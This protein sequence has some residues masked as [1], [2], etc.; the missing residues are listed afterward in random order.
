MVDVLLGEVNPN[1]AS[2]LGVTLFAGVFV[3]VLLQMASV[4]RHVDGD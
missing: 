2:A 3:V 1:Y 4:Y